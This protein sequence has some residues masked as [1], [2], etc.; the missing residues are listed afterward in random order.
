MIFK[1]GLAQYDLETLS[2]RKPMELKRW[3]LVENT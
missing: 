3:V 1:T 2:V